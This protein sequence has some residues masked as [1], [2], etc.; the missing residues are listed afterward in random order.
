MKIIHLIS[1]HQWTGPAE[2]VVKVAKFLKS[3]KEQVIIG[4]RN[5]YKGEFKN[6]LIKQGIDFTECLSFPRGFKPTMM[7]KD[8]TNL[9]KIIETFSPDIV[10]CHNSI[11]N[12]Y[13]S[14]IKIR[15]KNFILV[16]SIHNSKYLTKK[17]FAKILFNSNDY[18]LTNCNYFKRE[19]I[20]K[21]NL[22]ENKIDVIKGFVDLK[23]FKPEG[24][25]DFLEKNYKIKNSVNIGMVARFQPHRGHKYL[26]DAFIKLAKKFENI[27]LILTGRG[28]SLIPLKEYVKNLNLSDRIIFTGYIGEDLPELL[29]SLDIF[30]LLQEGSDG[31]C[32]AVLEAMA[33]GLPIITVKRGALKETIVEE[34]NGFF[35]SDKRDVQQLVHK[36]QL[37]IESHEIRERMGRLSRIFAENDFSEDKQLEKYYKFYRR[38]LNERDF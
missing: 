30:V 4:F 21:F 22:P 32:R 3:K 20:E 16:R 1:L 18:L 23:K 10:H 29:R 19:M 15:R 34:E 37:L 12:I 5:F 9:T 24:N 31:T 36:L 8:F 2:Y 7:I 27:R 6:R 35:I 25:K 28:E 26:I 33:T 38:I 17:P 13:S 14:L 11:E